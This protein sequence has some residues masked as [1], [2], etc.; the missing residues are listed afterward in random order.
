VVQVLVRCVACKTCIAVMEDAEIEGALADDPLAIGLASLPGSAAVASANA[1][2]SAACDPGVFESLQTAND[3]G[4][5]LAASPTRGGH[6]GR[7]GG[8]AWGTPESKATDNKSM[9]QG[10]MEEEVRFAEMESRMRSMI[11]DVVKPTVYRT[12]RLQQEHDSMCKKFEEMC[13]MHQGVIDAQNEAKA[14]IEMIQYFKEELDRFWHSN[15]ALEDKMTVYQKTAMERILEN[16]KTCESIQSTCARQCNNIDRNMQDVHRLQDLHKSLEVALEHSSQ[17]SKERIDAEVMQI[18]HQI[19]DVR[20]LHQRLTED[21]WGEEDCLDVSPPSLRRLDMQMRRT[22]S[23]LTEVVDDI[24]GL[25]KIEQDMLAI[26]KRQ[27]I[28]EQQIST[29]DMACKDVRERMEKLADDS[30]KDFNQASNLMAALSAN[31]VREARSNFSDEIKAAQQMRH[32]VDDFVRQTQASMTELEAH[33]RTSSKHCE[34]VLREVRTDVGNL[35]EKRKRDKQGLEEDMRGVR[36]RVGNALESTAAMLRGLEHVSGVMSMSLQSERMSIALDLQD[37]VERKDSHYIG[38]CE[39][40]IT[41]RWRGIRSADG[42]RTPIDPKQMVRQTYQPKPVSYQGT[43][44]ERLQL[45]ALREKLVHAAQEVLSQGPHKAGAKAQRQ[46]G[47]DMSFSPAPGFA[48]MIVGCMAETP[49]SDKAFRCA[50]SCSARPGSRGQPSARGSPLLEDAICRPGN[51]PAASDD[52]AATAQSAQ[53]GA[54]GGT[55]QIGASVSPRVPPSGVVPEADSQPVAPSDHSDAAGLEWI[56][57]PCAKTLAVGKPHRPTGCQ[58]PGA[59]PRP[60]LDKVAARATLPDHDAVQHRMTLSQMPVDRF[61]D[62]VC[63]AESV[64]VERCAATAAVRLPSLAAGIERADDT[65]LRVNAPPLTA[66]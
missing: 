51:W 52:T 24:G 49:S 55:P 58:R 4:S 60:G 50:S 36:N 32:D 26:H 17:R 5:A 27:T 7:R 20:D 10:R 37:F 21:V 3:T 42:A 33:I 66:R 62:L 30:K 23:K 56:K 46:L 63:G 48:P 64:T 19:V 34:A 29:S 1:R 41:E 38:I 40:S 25:S 53:P 13:A 35:D 28:V 54:H 57:Q 44:F 11:V 31:L 14:H 45:L 6:D 43:S 59:G 15:N 61:A 12:T 22:M 47:G 39:T 8:M 18:Q 2:R 9:L 65:C 16:E